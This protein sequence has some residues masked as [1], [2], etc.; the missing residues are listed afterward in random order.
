MSRI[1]TGGISH[2]AQAI[3][4]DLKTRT[5]NLH[6]PHI[7]SLS[8]LASCVLSCRNVNSSE[9]MAILP[10]QTGDEKS[11][12]RF[13]SR[14]LSN[15]LIDPI[16]VMHGFIPDIVA[17][18]TQNGKSL[19][20]MLDQSK[21]SNGFE[22]LMV[23]VRLG[24]RA[25]PVTWSV[26]ETKGA[27]GFDIQEKLLNHVL[28]MI[29]KGISIMLSADRFYGTSMMIDWCIKAGWQY[30]I[31][32]KSN[33][34]LDHEGGEIT[35]G[36]AAAMKLHSLENARFSK[37]LVQTNIGILH[38]EGHFEPWIIAMNCKPSEYKVLDY[39]M[40]WGIECMFSD[41][42][43]RGFSITQTHLKHTD[44]VERLILILT[45]ALYWA[46]SAG[47]SVVPRPKDTKK[48]P[49]VL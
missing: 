29:P 37:T 14:V 45:I 41:F 32:L 17:K 40:R 43:S 42:K 25:I 36:D 27:I 3:E 5:T 11:K 15:P 39:S 7:R 44:R 16:K 12:E 22:C 19:I 48:K 13:I 34:I 23:S 30:R 8:D 9:W 31:R 26:V 10:R 35:T 2:L 21:I 38:E 1:T 46:I 4:N 33:L 6:K 18:L 28:A 24:A 20:L 49:P 47:M